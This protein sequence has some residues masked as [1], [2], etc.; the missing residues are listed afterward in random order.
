MKRRP[1]L[2]RKDIFT[3]NQSI[4]KPGS[5]QTS[6]GLLANKVTSPSTSTSTKRM[7]FWLER[8]TIEKIKAKAAQEKT[9]A[10]DILREILR[11][12]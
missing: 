12:K 4:S 9:T 8:Q 1:R 7:T 11:E 6:K 10:S 5:Q 3:D 2:G